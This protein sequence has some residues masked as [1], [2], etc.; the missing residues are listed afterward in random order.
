VALLR[1]FY[2]LKVALPR[3]KGGAVFI[4]CMLPVDKTPVVDQNPS[5]G[6]IPTLRILLDKTSIL[7]SALLPTLRTVSFAGGF[8]VFAG[9]I[10]VFAGA[11][12]VFAGAIFVFA[13]VLGRFLTYR[14]GTCKVEG[15]KGSKGFKEKH[16]G[17]GNACGKPFQPGTIVS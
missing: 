11:I 15:L 5:C 7:N 8:F 6:Q 17:N 16:V 14:L 9:A 10:F 12:F 2:A 1:R 3:I 4:S 13:G